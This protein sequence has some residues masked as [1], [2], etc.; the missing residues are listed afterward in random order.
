MTDKAEDICKGDLSLGSGCK[1]CARCAQQFEARISALQDERDLRTVQCDGTIERAQLMLNSKNRWK[2]RAVAAETQ[3]SVLRG[4]WDQCRQAAQAVVNRWASPLWRQEVGTNSLIND[5]R[6]AI[7]ISPSAREPQTD[8]P[9]PMQ[10][11]IVSEPAGIHRFKENRIVS[12]LVEHGHKTGYGPNQIACDDY[13]PDE[14]MQ[15]AQLI[16]YSVDGHGTLSYVTDESFKRAA[17]MSQRVA[18]HHAKGATDD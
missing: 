11:V 18:T 9:S 1:R 14:R 7:A 10:P 5:L 3:L 15:L 8:D 12:K 16:G 17:A 13:T 4:D 2:E 6:N